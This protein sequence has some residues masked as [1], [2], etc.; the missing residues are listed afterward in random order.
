MSLSEAQ[1]FTPFAL[2][3]PGTAMNGAKLTSIERVERQAGIKTWL[4]MVSFVYGTCAIPDG[5]ESRAPG[6]QRFG[7][8]RSLA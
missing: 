4:N 2:Y 3:W 6:N 7:D 5:G 8:C 1:A